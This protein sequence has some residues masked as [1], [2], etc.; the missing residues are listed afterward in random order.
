[1]TLEFPDRET[2]PL[3]DFRDSGGTEVD[4]RLTFLYRRLAYWIVGNT[5][6]RP[7]QAVALS[8]LK[9]SMD[10]SLGVLR[11]DQLED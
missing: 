11:L 1:M 5:A 3:I 10:Y 2:D 8:R 7:E 9:D 4:V 6:R